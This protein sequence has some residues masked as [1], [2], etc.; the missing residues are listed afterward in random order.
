[1]R[2]MQKLPPL[3]DRGWTPEEM[4]TL[5]GL[6]EGY[7]WRRPYQGSMGQVTDTVEI[8]VHGLRVALIAP[9]VG[10]A[11]WVAAIGQ[12]RDDLARRQ[13]IWVTRFDR[14]VDY[15]VGWVRKYPEAIAAEALAHHEALMK[16]RR[17]GVP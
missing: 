11:G 16:D 12:H 3:G 10:R 1:M 14:G 5:P 9:L 4:A 13:H 6:P 15:V 2:G 7:C 17:W 8:A